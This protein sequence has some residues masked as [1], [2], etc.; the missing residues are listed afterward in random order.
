MDAAAAGILHLGSQKA[1]D[2]M[3]AHAWTSCDDEHVIGGASAEPLP[4][5]AAFGPVT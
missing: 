3:T 2:T 5:L 4:P 1:G